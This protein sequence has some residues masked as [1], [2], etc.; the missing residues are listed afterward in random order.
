MAKRYR[1]CDKEN[2]GGNRMSLL[3]YVI[4]IIIDNIEVVGGFLAS[5]WE[6]SKS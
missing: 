6:V 1:V 5:K 3:D 2:V 4:T